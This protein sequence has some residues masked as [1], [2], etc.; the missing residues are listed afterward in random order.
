V[1]FSNQKA[2]QTSQE[3]NDEAIEKYFLYNNPKEKPVKFD[4]DEWVFLKVKIFQGKS[5]N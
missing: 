4:V 2:R 1:H 3:N 5:N